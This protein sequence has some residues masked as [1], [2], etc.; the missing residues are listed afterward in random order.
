MM[1]QKSP[2]PL[3]HR[4]FVVLNTPLPRKVVPYVMSVQRPDAI[5]EPI[6][7]AV[8]AEDRHMSKREIEKFL[9]MPQCGPRYTVVEV[10]IPDAFLRAGQPPQMR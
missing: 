3:I 4:L 7:Q 1:C 2:F 8:T 10:N 6:W 9:L 5:T